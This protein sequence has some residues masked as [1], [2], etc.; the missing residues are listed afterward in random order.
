MPGILLLFSNKMNQEKLCCLVMWLKISSF[1]KVNADRA[2]NYFTDTEEVK[3]EVG[4]N[5]VVPNW[6]S[7]YQVKWQTNPISTCHSQKGYLL[8]LHLQLR[9]SSCLCTSTVQ[10][11]LVQRRLSQVQTSKPWNLLQDKYRSELLISRASRNTQLPG[12]GAPG[13]PLL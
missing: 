12:A 9:I 11:S 10:S 7:V 8:C 4:K 13:R 2:Q 5:Q 6:P 1:Q 3:A